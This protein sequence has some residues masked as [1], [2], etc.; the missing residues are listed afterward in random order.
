[1]KRINE[2]KQYSL[3]RIIKDVNKLMDTVGEEYP[4]HDISISIASLD[5]CFSFETNVSYNNKKQEL[6][7]E[8]KRQNQE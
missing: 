5:D 4:R 3:N 2:E 7:Y 6:N 8:K 1:M